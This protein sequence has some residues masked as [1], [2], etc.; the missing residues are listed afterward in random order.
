MPLKHAL[1][2][3]LEGGVVVLLHEVPELFEAFTR[4]DAAAPATVGVGADAAGL[5]V[6]LVEGA[7][8]AEAD[9]E[10]F[11]E[12]THAAFASLKG[13]DDLAAEVVAVGHA[14]AYS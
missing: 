8:E 11:G 3:L 7:D 10:A 2:E 4:E 5:A 6:V 13:G 1:G 9:V 12:F 14:S